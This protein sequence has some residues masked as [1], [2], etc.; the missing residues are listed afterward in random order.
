MSLPY[1]Y[2]MTYGTTNSSI[3]WS[4]TNTLRWKGAGQ[5]RIGTETTAQQVVLHPTANAAERYLIV[6]V[7][8]GDYA[9]LLRLVTGKK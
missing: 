8:G 6:E 4:L 7:S 9:G 2:R 1:G 5:P 3:S